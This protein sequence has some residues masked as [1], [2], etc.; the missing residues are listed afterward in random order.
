MGTKGLLA[1]Q[2]SKYA[3]CSLKP[4]PRT[5]A[6]RLVQIATRSDDYTERS[7][8]LCFGNNAGQQKAHVTELTQLLSI[9]AQQTTCLSP[10][11]RNFPHR[12]DLSTSGLLGKRSFQNNV[13]KHYLVAVVESVKVRAGQTKSA[14][15]CLLGP[16]PIAM[17][18]STDP[19]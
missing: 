1:W 8:S 15:G 4:N 9:V 11:R 18:S 10:V 16:D 17:A 5:H 13:Y 3:S 14:A 12:G 6:V 7:P 19:R 2:R